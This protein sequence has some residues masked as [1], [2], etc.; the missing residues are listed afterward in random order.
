[1]LQTLV[2]YE[3]IPCIVAIATMSSQTN[4]KIVDLSRDDCSQMSMK[5]FSPA[6]QKTQKSVLVH[7]CCSVSVFLCARELQASGGGGGGGEEF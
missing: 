3:V 7:D 6:G 5:P 4:E 1:M 2:I